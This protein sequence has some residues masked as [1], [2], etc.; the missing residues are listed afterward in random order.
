VDTFN[1]ELMLR[2]MS[3][4]DRLIMDHDISWFKRSSVVNNKNLFNFYITTDFATSEKT[5]ADFS[6]ISVWAYNNNGD[7]LWVDGVCK[8]QLMD[9]NIND[10]FRLAQEYRPQ[11]VGIEV[12]G[13]QGGFIQWVQDQMLQRNIYFPL[14]SEGNNQRPGIR[15]NTNKMVRF[16]TMVPLFKANKIFFPTEYKEN[17]VIIEAMDEL[18]LASPGGFKSKHDDFIDTISMLSSLNPWK[19]TQQ[20]NLKNSSDGDIWDVDIDTQD[21]NRI[22]SYIV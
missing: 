19:P 12:T 15:P 10:L 1:Q 21:E 7:W 22:T 13:Q 8:R 2:I 3:D 20:G 6:V 4:E 16:N 18:S 5:S 14:A 17:P 9:Q 11:Q